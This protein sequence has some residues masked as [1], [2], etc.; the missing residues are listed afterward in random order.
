MPTS[1]DVAKWMQEKVTKEQELFQI[2]AV[3]EIQEQFGDEFIY[4]ND[5]GNPAI[6]RAVLKEFGKLTKETVVWERGGRYWRLRD[7][8][9]TP[10]KRQSDY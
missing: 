10:G 5:N 3:S 1:E 9:D 4:L 2:E 7:K 8:H 6:S